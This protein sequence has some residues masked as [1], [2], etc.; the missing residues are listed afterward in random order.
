MQYLGKMQKKRKKLQQVIS[1]LCPF[2]LGD[3][4]GGVDA[5]PP[6]FSQNNKA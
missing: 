6:H 4:G 2:L 3:N 1:D 5:C